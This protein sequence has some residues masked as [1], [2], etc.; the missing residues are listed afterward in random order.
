MS[1]KAGSVHNELSA[2]TSRMKFLGILII[3]TFLTA[4]IFS[5]IS[6]GAGNNPE[7]S[8]NDKD[9]NLMKDDTAKVK[10]KNNVIKKIEMNKQRRAAG[11]R[12]APATDP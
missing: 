4:I 7:I 10:E 2:K 5:G 8:D 3:G 11:A 9:A 1:L 12:S 6:L